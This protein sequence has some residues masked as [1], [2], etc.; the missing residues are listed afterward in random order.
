MAEEDSMNVSQKHDRGKQYGCIA[1]SIA[2]ESSLN[3]SQAHG[4]VDASQGA[5]QREAV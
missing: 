1:G 5:W 4:S 2:K 3:A